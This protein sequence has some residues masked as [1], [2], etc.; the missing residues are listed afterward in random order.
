MAKNGTEFSK[1]AKAFYKNIEGEKSGKA[2]FVKMLLQMG[3]SKNGKIIID[4]LFPTETTSRGNTIIKKAA[5]RLRKY[6]RGE[7]DISDIADEVYAALDHENY[8]DYIKALAS[9]LRALAS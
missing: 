4:E 1:Y 9:Q 7:N 2:E 8:G 6:F 3:L 5:D